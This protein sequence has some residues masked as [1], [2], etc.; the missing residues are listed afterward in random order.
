[1]FNHYLIIIFRGLRRFKGSFIINM[2]SLSVGLACALLFYLWITDELNVDKFH[3]N[4]QRLFQVFEHRLGTDDIHTSTTTSGIMGESL[5]SEM[6]EIEQ[7]INISW[8]QHATLSIND[9]NIKST[10]YY[11]GEAFFEMFSYN[12][13]KGD[14]NN[15]LTDISSI[16]LSESF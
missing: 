11:A 3:V 2:V 16:V 14:E 9:K 12:L 7:A 15:V 13:I 8:S 10:G 4:D 6:P 1:M 5:V